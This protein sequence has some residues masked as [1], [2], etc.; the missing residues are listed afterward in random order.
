[1]AELAVPFESAPA[2]ACSRIKELKI[3]SQLGAN[4]P[5]ATLLALLERL[6]DLQSLELRGVALP[7]SDMEVSLASHALSLLPQLTKLT[8]SDF[9]YLSCIPPP[10][11]ANLTHLTVAAAEAEQRARPKARDLAPHLTGLT[12]L[13]E[14]R[15]FATKAYGFSPSGVVQLHRAIPLQPSLRKLS[16]SPVA[17]ST[18][19]KGCSVGSLV[20]A[21]TGGQ[22]QTVEISTGR[23]SRAYRDLAA[24]LAAAVLPSSLLRR[25]LP[26][27]RV[28]GTISVS[29]GPRDPDPAAALLAR[30]DE[31]CSDK[32]SGGAS[33]Q[34]TYGVIQRLG[35][36]KQFAWDAGPGVRVEVRLRPFKPT[37]PAGVR[38]QRGGG[39]GGDGQ[40]QPAAPLEASELL[41]RA[42]ER[43]RWRAGRPR[44]RYL[45]LLSGRTVQRLLPD[46]HALA[47]WL[48]RLGADAAAGGGDTDEGGPVASYRALPDVGCVVLACR[49]EAA[50]DAVL[51][52]AM[53]TAPPPLGSATGGAA[54]IGSGGD[55]GGSGSG[56]S[57]GGGT[58]STS[59]GGGGGGGGGGRYD[60][61][62]EP[63][64]MGWGEALRKVL[65][66]LWD[67]KPRRGAHT[68]AGAPSSR[69]DGG[70]AGELDR[71]RWLLETW[72]GL[73]TL[74]SEE[75]LTLEAAGPEPAPHAQ[76]PQIHGPPA[77]PQQQPPLA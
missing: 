65:Q 25:R 72:E 47:A 35:L 6:P 66:A 58:A 16:L 3:I 20:F 69:S 55:G 19:S 4:L 45:L 32:L 37:P 41:R 7:S 75:P 26:C 39:D 60:L 36:P 67:G 59:A 51:W 13:A 54:D 38:R 73:R 12:S 76:E 70:P 9:W 22:L 10:L 77:A 18:H 29:N 24:L 27:L 63:A 57:G 46:P 17:C 50:W 14:L 23:R 2:W 8:V 11:A 52:A 31:I 48:Q 28:L 71:V 21:F 56:G 68:N 49:S 74:P 61:T 64:A 30:C 5:G 43:M 33:A 62:A 34:A 40:P 53:W 15:L 1:M 42:L 44:E